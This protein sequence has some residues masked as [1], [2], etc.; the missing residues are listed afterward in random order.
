MGLSPENRSAPTAA[1]PSRAKLASNMA[2]N[3]AGALAEAATAFLLAPFLVRLLGEE[4]YGL[5]ILLGS[6]VSY[7]GLVDLGVRGSVGRYVAFYRS[8]GDAA[9]VRSSLRSGFALASVAGGVVMLLAIGID[10]GF[11]RVFD[12]P[13]E[14]VPQLRLTLWLVVLNLAV[15]LPLSLFDAVLWGAERFDRLNQIGVPAAFTRLVASYWVVRSGYGLVGLAASTLCLTLLVGAAKLVAAARVEPA[16]F[17]RGPGGTVQMA[18]TLL[19]YGVPLFVISISRM[20]RLQLVPAAVGWALGAASVTH[21]SLSR[22]L[23]DYAEGFLVSLTGVVTPTF[24]LLQARGNVDHQQALYTLGGRLSTALGLLF[25]GFAVVLG[26]PFLSLWLGSK[27]ASFAPLMWVLALG[28]V[29]PFSQSITG[30]MLLGVA[31]HRVLAGLL[32]AEVVAIAVGAVTISNTYGLL[33][34][35]IV[36]AIAGTVF[37]GVLVMVQGCRVVGMSVARYLL[38]AIVP[39]FAVCGIATLGLKMLAATVPPTTWPRFA[40]DVAGYAVI[41]IAALVALG[42]QDVI[43]AVR[44]RILKAAT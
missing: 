20:T 14:A 42:G 32:V 19:Q 39:P 36:L 29:L 2:W 6:L 44:A 31:R 16:A 37:R 27:W 24:A 3:W 9:G 38:T 35:C 17:S 4:D 26:G 8:R 33:G 5:W 30:N 25:A 13:L 28:E 7:M 18:K 10:S 43:Q 23:V 41:S 15:S 12:I 1:A 34:L 40:L 21:Y 11:M 22:R